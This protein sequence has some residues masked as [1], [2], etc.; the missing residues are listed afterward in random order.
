MVKV[1]GSR[2]VVQNSGGEKTKKVLQ[3]ARRRGG[4]FPHIDLGFFS[5]ARYP[6]KTTGIKGGKRQTPHFVA[7]VAAWN[8]FGT[9][10]GV[11]E[12]PF[13]RGMLNELAKDK[14]FQELLLKVADAETMTI[15]RAGLEL[16]GH[17]TEGKLKRSIVDLKVPPNAP[18]VSY[19]HLTLPTKA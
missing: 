16:I 18:S 11:P 2:P 15:P 9:S 19:T 8:E 1:T 3:K 13:F 7:T 6:E 4:K 10:R 5:T 14:V 17:Y 12:R